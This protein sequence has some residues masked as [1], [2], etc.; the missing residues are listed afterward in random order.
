MKASSIAALFLATLIHIPG[1]GL[2]TF[3]PA[4]VESA[5]LDNKTMNIVMSVKLSDPCDQIATP[6]VVVDQNN[7]T[8]IKLEVLSRK[9]GDGCIEMTTDKI[10]TVNLPSLLEMSNVSISK[11]KTY[12]ILFDESDTELVVPG[13]NLVISTQPQP[14]LE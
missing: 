4:H 13:K 2:S 8:H 6:Q 11:Y 7:P 5:F 12:T 14:V 9:S 10:Q 3:L 1:Y